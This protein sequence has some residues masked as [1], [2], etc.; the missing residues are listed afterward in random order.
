MGS[1]A[2]L[3]A[4][5]FEYAITRLRLDIGGRSLS[6]PLA[7]PLVLRNRLTFFLTTPAFACARSRLGGTMLL[8]TNPP[9]AAAYFDAW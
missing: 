2:W 6:L 1:C 4:N 8:R 9:G 7:G 5:S 3:D